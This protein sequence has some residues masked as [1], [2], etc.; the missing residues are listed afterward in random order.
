[1]FKNNLKIAWRNF[2]KDRQFTFLNLMG[3][4]TG[5]ACV[6]IIYLWVNDELHVD[7]FNE[8]DE[9][10]FQVMRNTPGAN[11]IETGEQTP[12]LLADALAK[13]MPEV[14]YATAVI[15]VSWSDKKVILSVG[16]KRIM[17]TEQ[18]AGK[19]YFN[20]F[21]YRLIQGDKNQVLAD[22]N[23]I[24]IS[25]EMALK[26]FNTTENI[27]GKTV[28]LNQKEYSGNYLISGIFEDPPANATARFDM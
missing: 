9:Q 14:E 12:G 23:S 6:L 24:V 28:A 5:L 22:K 17:G 3:L 18:F 1:M 19:D 11:G 4:S 26:L 2:L 25:K 10:L 7:R 27:V 16:D 21:S 13:E 15:P 20:V 8:K